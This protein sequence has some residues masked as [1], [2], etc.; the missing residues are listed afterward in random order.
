[1][2]ILLGINT[3][4]FSRRNKLALEGKAVNEDSPGF[5]YTI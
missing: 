5:Y 4:V 3:F 1:M 2:L